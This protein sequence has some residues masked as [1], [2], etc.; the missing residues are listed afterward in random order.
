[1]IKTDMEIIEFFISSAHSEVK[2]RGMSKFVAHDFYF[3][4]LL[5]GKLNFDDY[6]AHEGA[7]SY[8]CSVETLKIV[9]VNSGYEAFIIHH[10]LDNVESFYADLP[11]TLQFDI[12]NGIIQSI[13]SRY[14][15]GEEV[16]RYIRNAFKPI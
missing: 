9:K 1:M 4:S 13:V 8:N 11:V 16:Q 12:E 15:A 10:I 7:F 5:K 6:C 3:D 2:M 14:E